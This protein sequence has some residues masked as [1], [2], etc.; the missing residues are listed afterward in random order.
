M[1]FLVALLP[2]FLLSCS[3]L[4]KPDD[5]KSLD[6]I[7]SS[8]N[9]ISLAV[10]SDDSTLL[11]SDDISTEELPVLLSY[12]SGEFIN[13]K[14]RLRGQTTLETYPRSFSIDIRQSSTVTISN[15]SVERF[16]LIPLRGDTNTI[17]GLMG[18]FFAKK[19]K[20]FSPEIN[21]VSLKLND[22]HL[23]T[24]LIF[25]HNTDAIVG[26][27][28]TTEFILRRRYGS[29]YDV[30]YYEQKDSLHQLSRGDY[31]KSYEALHTL[32]TLYQDEEL[33]AI[34]E[35]KMDLQSYL[36]SLAFNKVFANGDYSD[37]MFYAG[38]AQRDSNGV[39]T[40]YFT[41]SVWDLSEL[42]SEP[43]D[44]KQKENSLIF[45]N[46]NR[47]DEMI[48]ESPFLY[49]KYCTVLHDYLEQS[50]TDEIIIECREF[51]DDLLTSVLNGGE[52]RVEDSS[53]SLDE[54][55][56]LFDETAEL[57]IEN[58]LEIMAELGEI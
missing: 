4:L 52:L 51:I 8:Q 32:S 50:I 33:V 14:V 30:K 19:A 22:S 2:L 34:L 13:G 54:I 31:T 44:G 21:L 6:P 16:S 35:K 36:T 9:E 17:Y 37:E 45:C 46:E 10:S 20:L 47:F 18:L 42:F 28:S 11:L 56:V 7:T 55:M 15:K 3:L 48:E 41:F 49:K 12:N 53:Y 23:G 27:K 1:R 5:V 57:L 25:E 39:T 40:P 38:S 29:F 26:D 24:Y 43:Y 58:K